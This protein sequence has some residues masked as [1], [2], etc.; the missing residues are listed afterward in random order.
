MSSTGSLISHW[1]VP[2]PVQEEQANLLGELAM[3]R[4]YQHPHLVGFIG[5]AIAMERGVDT[6]MLAMELC[7][8]GALR[9]T[10]KLDITW[11]LKVCRSRN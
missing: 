7:C 8:N 10:L 2:A 5:T 1:A 9:E 3:L 6:V 4:H 11:P